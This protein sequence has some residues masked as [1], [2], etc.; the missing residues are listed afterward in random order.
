MAREDRLLTRRALVWLFLLNT[1]ICQD[2]PLYV[3]NHI[4]TLYIEWTEKLTNN[5]TIGCTLAQ[6]NS[7]LYC[8]AEAVFISAM[9]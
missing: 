4:P 2:M 9:L 7:A 5:N 8:R 1:Y 3:T 6:P